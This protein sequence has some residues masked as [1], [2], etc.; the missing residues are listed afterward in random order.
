MK[1]STCHW[2]A[3]TLTLNICFVR[4]GH[5]RTCT[6]TTHATQHKSNI[7]NLYTYPTENNVNGATFLML[8]KDDLKEIVKSVGTVRQLQQ[9]QNQLL[10]TIVSTLSLCL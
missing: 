5:T 6:H 1:F 3:L 9:L 10:G 4:P 8:E 7:C 2:Q